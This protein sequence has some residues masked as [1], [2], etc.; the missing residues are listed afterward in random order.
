MVASVIDLATP[1]ISFFAA[2][3]GGLVAHYLSISRDRAAKRRELMIKHKIELW[4]SIDQQNED[5]T[6][7]FENRIPDYSAWEGIVSDIQL[8]GSNK[9]IEQAYDI[10]VSI[11][12]KKYVS[13][14]PLLTSLQHDLR[15]ELGLEKAKKE[16]F[17]FRTG[18][19]KASTDASKQK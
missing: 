13:F 5:A 1:F 10:I 8:L 14:I 11:S 12:E 19:S 17:W 4:K 9:Q 7:T 16:Y 3:V 6:A 18:K 2:L 15:E